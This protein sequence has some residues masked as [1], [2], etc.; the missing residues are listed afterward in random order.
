M[1]QVNYAARVRDFERRLLKQALRKS[2]GNMSEAGRALGLHRNTMA[3]RC[4]ALDVNP[5]LFIPKGKIDYNAKYRAKRR[6]AG[7]CLSCGNNPSGGEGGTL[8][9]CQECAEANR[10][11]MRKGGMPGRK[12][13]LE[14][15]VPRPIDQVFRDKQPEGA[16]EQRASL[17]MARPR[18]SELLKLSAMMPKS[19]VNPNELRRQ[20]VC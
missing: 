10:K 1:S 4:R 13:N 20:S 9:Q 16:R 14:V 6:V 11:R 19:A 17:P 18:I 12:K 7:M 15:I 3:D 8:T 5:T 2:H